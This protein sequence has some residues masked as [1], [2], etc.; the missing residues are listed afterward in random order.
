[1]G[2]R[3]NDYVTQLRLNRAKELLMSTRMSVKEITAACGYYSQSHFTRLFLE[4]EG[5]TPSE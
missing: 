4:H 2:I 3:Y 5:C 1:M